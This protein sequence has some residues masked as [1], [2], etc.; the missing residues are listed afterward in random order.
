MTD[1]TETYDAHETAKPNEPTFTVQ[2]G[3]P[4]GPWT[5]QFWADLARATARSLL[6]GTTI[7]RPRYEFVTTEASDDFEPSEADKVAADVWLRKATAA[8]Q[9]GWTMKAYQRGEA[10]APE[11]KTEVSAEAADAATVES[12]AA[13]IKQAGRLHNAIGIAKDAE[14]ALATLGVLEPVQAAILNAIDQLKA[15]AEAIDPRKPG[16]R[17]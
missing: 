15:C 3:D 13:L 10:D 6:D 14:E 16:E 2:G 4:A 9:V 1:D 5:V 11:T 17:S 7:R 8:E 12:R